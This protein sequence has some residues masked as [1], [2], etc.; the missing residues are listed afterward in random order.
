MCVYV[1]YVCVFFFVLW[2]YS[3]C[4]WLCLIFVGTWGNLPVKRESVISVSATRLLL[5]S[6]SLFYLP[7][8]IVCA[9]GTFVRPCGVVSLGKEPKRSSLFKLLVFCKIIIS[10]LP[11]IPFPAKRNPGS[12][13]LSYFVWLLQELQQFAISRAV[14]WSYITRWWAQRNRCSS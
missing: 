4:C 5:H 10:L 7:T 14:I 8:K 9:F 6:S 11:S 2:R 13:C 12:F 1:L 3:I